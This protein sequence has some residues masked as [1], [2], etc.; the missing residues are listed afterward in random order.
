MQRPGF[1][2]TNPDSSTIVKP[3][4]KQKQEARKFQKIFG[5]AKSEYPTSCI[6]AA[7]VEPNKKHTTHVTKG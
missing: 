3:H 2:D 4:T 5:K 7:T 1:S 6:V